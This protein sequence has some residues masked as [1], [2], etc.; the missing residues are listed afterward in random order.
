MIVTGIV[1]GVFYRM[2]TPRWA[3]APTS[4]AGAARHGGRLNRSGVEALYLS[5]QTDT[6]ISEYQQTSAV[7][8]PG[9]LVSYRVSVSKVADFSAGYGPDWDPLWQDFDCDW[10]RLVFNDK[11][12]PPTWVI[13]DMVMAAG[14]QGILFPSIAKPGGTNLVLFH[15][16]LTARDKLQAIDPQGDLPKTQSSWT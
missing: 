8:P 2:N 3:F 4:G 12:E 13:S 7:L 15:A 11:I 1:D 14:C 9:T 16:M 6:A 5:A 10:R